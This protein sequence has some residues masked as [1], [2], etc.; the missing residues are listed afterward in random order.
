MHFH[1]IRAQT[2]LA[3]L[4]VEHTCYLKKG[5][6]NRAHDET[7]RAA[8]ACVQQWRSSPLSS[9]AGWWQGKVNG[10]SGGASGW[11][12]ELA[13][14]GTVTGG[15]VPTPR[16]WEGPGLPIDIA[17][18]LWFHKAL[19]SCFAKVCASG[20]H[21][22]PKVLLGLDSNSL[23]QMIW[24]WKDGIS[25][26]W[27]PAPQFQYCQGKINVMWQE[28]CVQREWTWNK[29]FSILWI[30]FEW[31]FPSANTWTWLAFAPLNKLRWWCS[32][33]LIHFPQF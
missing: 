26:A 13:E 25:C 29:C 11:D 23:Y 21:V 27:P 1:L 18:S 31:Q 10:R 14:G 24:T 5:S 7:T 8:A 22:L 16:P 32:S 6:C 4:P 9:L 30:K 20:I 19:Y 28:N 15:G 3:L 12:E 33:H 2:L 17:S